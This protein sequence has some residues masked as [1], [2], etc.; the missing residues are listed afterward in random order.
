MRFHTPN[1]RWAITAGLA[2]CSN[3]IE[4]KSLVERC[5]DRMNEYFIEPIDCTEDG[6]Y[7]R[8][9]SGNYNAVVNTAM[10]ILRN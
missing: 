7:S 8:R 3:I 2:A 1:H 6:E 10:I 4:D 9:S 5:I